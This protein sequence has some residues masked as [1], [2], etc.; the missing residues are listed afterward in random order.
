V[1][2][3]FWCRFAGTRT[4]Q[5][6]VAGL[7]CGDAQSGYGYLLAIHEPIADFS[8]SSAPRNCFNRRLDI[9]RVVVQL[10]TVIALLIHHPGTTT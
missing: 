1:T 5:S 8:I 10:L 3:S 2:V 9:P 7:R 6:P 4:T